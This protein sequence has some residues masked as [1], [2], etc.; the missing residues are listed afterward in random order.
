MPLLP[1]ISIVTPSYN[2]AQYLEECIDS[3]LSQGYPNLEYVVMDGGSTDG[4]VEIIKKYERHLTYWQSCSDG[5]Q[6]AAIN[7]GFARTTGEIMAWLNSDDRYHPNAFL[8]IATV[9]SEYKEVDWITGIRTLWG[10]TGGILQIERGLTCFSRRKFLTGGFGKPCIQQEST[11]WR[12]SLWSTAGGF[13]NIEFTLAADA[14]LWLRFFRHKAIYRLNAFIG[15]FR[16]YGDQRSLLNMEQYVKE[17][18]HE[19]DRELFELPPDTKFNPMPKQIYIPPETYLKYAQDYS[20][21]RFKTDNSLWQN[22]IRSVTD[23]IF[24]RQGGLEAAQLFLDE[25]LLWD[26]E[27]NSVSSTLVKQLNYQISLVAVAEE[28]LKQS[29]ENYRIGDIDASIRANSEALAHWPTSATGYNNFGVLFYLRGEFERAIACLQLATQC[30]PSKR[31]AYRNLAII[32]HKLG[33]KDD[34][35]LL[36]DYYLSCFPD[37]IEMEQFYVRLTEWT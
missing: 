28:K 24:E 11:F 35:L 37:D 10:H 8:K 2:Q 6:Y 29:E 25:V 13:L 18:K 33:Q 7:A 26:N 22:Y 16:L 12:R 34:L 17:I 4:S 31:E 9:F 15:G 14:E 23:W 32:Y 20:I 27:V 21:P 19:I 3:V 1:R 30:D 5:G 36:I